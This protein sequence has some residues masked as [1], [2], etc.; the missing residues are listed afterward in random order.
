MSELIFENVIKRYGKKVVLKNISFEVNKGSLVGL[1]G[2]NGAGKT[3]TIKLIAGL[4]KVDSGKILVNG[5]DPFTQHAD[6]L[7]EVGILIE[8]QFFPYLTAYE[9]LAYLSSAMG[10][11]KHQ[12]DSLLE[13]VGLKNERNKKVSSFSFGMKQRLGLAQALLGNPSIVILDE[14]NIGLDP[15]GIIDLK[16]SLKKLVEEKKIV[17]IS[18]HIL[19]MVEDLCTEIIFI[20]NGEIIY[21]GELEKLFLMK[22]KFRLKGKPVDKIKRFLIQTNKNFLTFND[23]NALEFYASDEE[24][25]EIVQTLNSENCSILQVEQLSADLEEIFIDLVRRRKDG[26]DN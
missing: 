4:L 19:K 18:T 5:R 22:K 1:I 2:P 17:I 21:Q 15:M 26:K 9:N 20:N 8:P 7:K 24:M 16:N 13:F 6:A 14:P 3:T 12:I 10:L 11:D 25:R 23:S